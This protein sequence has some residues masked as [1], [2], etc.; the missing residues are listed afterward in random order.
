MKFILH[1]NAIP[2]PIAFNPICKC[3]RLTILLTLFSVLNGFANSYGQNLSLKMENASLADFFSEL[4]KQ[5]GYRFIYTREIIKKSRTLTITVKDRPLRE[6]LDQALSNQALQY[7]IA[8]KYVIIKEKKNMP[9][10]KE[11]LLLVPISGLVLDEHNQPVVGATVL[12]KST[13]EIVSTDKEGRFSLQT[14]AIGTVLVI[15][16]IGFEREELTITNQTDYRIQLKPR[17]SELEDVQVKVNTGY[18]VLPGERSTGSFAHVNNSQLN[19]QAGPNILDRLRGVTNGVLFDNKRTNGTTSKLGITVRGLSTLQASADPLVVLDNFPFEGDINSINPNDIESITVLKDAAAASIWG[20]RAGNGVIVINTKKGQYNQTLKLSV[21]ANSTLVEEPNLFDVPAISSSD[22]VDNELFLF[23]KNYRFGDTASRNRPSFSEA[24]EIL[25]RRRS[26]LITSSDSAAQINA[27][28]AYDV[29]NEFKKYMYRPAFNQQYAISM[30]GGSQQVNWLFSAGYDFNKSELDMPYK[31]LTLNLTNNFAVG[32][33]LS[34]TT[35]VSYFNTLSGNGNPAYNAIKNAIGNLDPYTRFADEQGNKVP[36][37][38]NYRLPYLDTVGNGKLLDWHFYPLDDHKNITNDVSINTILINLGTR[39]DI[40]KGLNI[41]FKYRYERQMTENTIEYGVQSYFTRDLINLYSQVNY[42]TGSVTNKVPVGGIVDKSTRTLDHH[43]GRVQLNFFK[44]LGQFDINWIAGSE[45]RQVRSS[46]N[47]HRVF[48]FNETNLGFSN[49]DL[50][51]AWPTFVTGGSSFI[52]NG[53]AFEKLNNRFFSM[54]SNMGLTYKGRYVMT[55]SARK[56]ASNLFGVNTNN[57][58]NP[59]W[60]AGLGWNISDEPFYQSSVLPYLKLSLSY[61]FSGNIDPTQS[62][63]TTIRYTSNS[64]FL[65]TQEADFNR[66]ANPDLRWEKIGQLNIGL[67][68]R[69]KNDRITGSIEYYRKNARDLLAQ[70][71]IDYTIG[72]N[73][74]TLVKNVGRLNT[75]G[76]DVLLNSNNLKGRLGWT[77]AFILN[78]ANDRLKE[79]Y[80]PRTSNLMVVDGGVSGVIGQP[81]YGIFSYRWSGLDPETGAPM[82]YVDGKVSK[83]YDSLTHAAYPIGDLVHHGTDVPRTFGSLINTFRYGKL[84]LSVAV[85]YRFNYYFRKASIN[86]YSLFQQNIGHADFGKR[87]QQP[88]DERHS[89]VPARYFP[90]DT[91]RETFYERS[92]VLVSRADNVRLQFLNLTYSPKINKN[93]LLNSVEFFGVASNLGLIWKKTSFDVDPDFQEL[94]PTKSYTLG[95][96]LQLK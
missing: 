3:M 47:S 78:T 58:W 46:S 60:S 45:L 76:V 38:R 21:F 70:L 4:R 23:S 12:V 54:F 20:A 56:D 64:P 5:T 69:A 72:L 13:G 29:R 2:R 80:N 61:G 17:P 44:R 1:G 81:V 35:G 89:F 27:L 77:T 7:T 82:G 49:T 79:F 28:R 74:R 59:L 48:G 93:P 71:P 18:Q 15:T 34:F 22:F 26:G 10:E 57:K 19:K 53:I 14:L 52:P 68:V 67:T 90:V 33:K 85:N 40:F 94:R 31:R 16:N 42:Q 65:G 43:S 30:T 75:R 83:R 37:R 8:D 91:Q 63:A 41:D 36:V 96:R 88:G 66:I 84:T 11:E 39:Y 32:R 24:Y 87:W 95:I 25:F 6:V 51:S 55:L 73:R 92:S 50:A 9:G 62:G 86:Y